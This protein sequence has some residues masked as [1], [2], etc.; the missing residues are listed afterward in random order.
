MLINAV[1]KRNWKT[2][3]NQ[4][5]PISVTA[6][7]KE[8]S[9]FGTERHLRVKKEEWI[10]VIYCH[11]R[12]CCVWVRALFQAPGK[13]QHSTAAL[14]EKRRC[15][16]HGRVGSKVLTYGERC[17]ERLV[18]RT[19]A[20]RWPGWFPGCFWR[21]QAV[22]GRR[23]GCCCCCF[24]NSAAWQ[25]WLRWPQTFHKSVLYWDSECRLQRCDG[26]GQA[27]AATDAATVGNIILGTEK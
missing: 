15:C 9:S 27:W 18:G 2:K 19:E 5:D 3:K 17:L 10:T 6:Q 21:C 1:D 7:F 4:T 20:G 22:F 8:Q 23:K 14:K 13:P 25:Q 12:F 26:R 24:F 11:F 16:H